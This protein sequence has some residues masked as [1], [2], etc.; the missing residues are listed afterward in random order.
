MH[1]GEGSDVRCQP[2]PQ[3]I[4]EGFIARAQNPGI[5]V[6]VT[7]HMAQ[8]GLRCEVGWP[9]VQLRV[10]PHPQEAKTIVQPT[11]AM[12]PNSGVLQ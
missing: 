5:T 7:L 11:A 9:V 12:A 8:M 2:G 4:E 10:E 1:C 6:T 3:E